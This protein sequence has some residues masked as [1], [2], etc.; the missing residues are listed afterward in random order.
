MTLTLNERV[1]LDAELEEWR[2]KPPES[3]AEYIKPGASSQSWVK[4]AMIVL[5]DA[6]L[7][8]HPVVIRVTTDGARTNITWE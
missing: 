7:A 6:A 8:G 2:Q 4:P 1:L 5:A 3:L